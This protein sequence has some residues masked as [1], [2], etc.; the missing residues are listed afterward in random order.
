MKKING[1]KNIFKIDKIKH[2]IKNIDFSNLNKKI[3]KYSINKTL[4]FYENYMLPNNE[5]L[6]RPSLL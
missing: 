5:N 6:N 1:F 2:N 4:Y 3:Y